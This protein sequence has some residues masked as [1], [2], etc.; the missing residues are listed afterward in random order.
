[1]QRPEEA[2]SYYQTALSLEEGWSKLAPSNMDAK[3]AISY[4]HSDIGFLLRE[5]GN[6]QESL[7]H[8]RAT[9]N[10][11]EESVAADPENA[12]AKLS[13]VSAYWRTASVSAAAGDRQASFELL[14]KAVA[15]LA[16]IKNP[17]P[18]SVR[19]QF[20]L[21]NIYAVY[22]ESYAAVGSGAVSRLWYERS[23]Q[24]LTA[25]SHSGELDANGADLLRS[26]EKALINSREK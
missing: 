16:H 11:R 23:K 24:T 5:E 13:L 8:Y 14:A 4:S 10:I 1:M 19:S 26:V 3:M 12:R 9:V 18:G 15:M 17:A 21:A 6:L 20:E 22:G 2:M 25:L 7:A